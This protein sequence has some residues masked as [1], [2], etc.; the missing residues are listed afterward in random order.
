MRFSSGAISTLSRWSAR[1]ALI[2]GGAAA[3]I[4]VALLA[5]RPDIDPSR[6][7]ISDYALGLHGW[8]MTT[9]FIAFAV[10][11][12]ALFL[13]LLD[14]VEGAAAWIGLLFLLAAA[15]GTAMAAYFPTDPM[16][17]SAGPTTF[18]GKMHGV[19]FMIGVPGEVFAALFLS[20]FLRK[21]VLWSRVPL[22]PLTALVWVSLIA[23]VGAMTLGAKGGG[24]DWIGWPNRLFMLGYAMW[25]IA[26]AY[27]L[28]KA[29]VMTPSAAAA[30][31]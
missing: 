30:R 6:Q 9:C 20:L 25:G 11:S 27:P 4:L 14:K 10:T 26:A 29:D 12:A 31:P 2:G 21:R 19:S 28:A 16:M 8:M 3:V 17:S 13:A 18:S 22:V 7:M 23:M 24:T 5:I 15:I 1:I